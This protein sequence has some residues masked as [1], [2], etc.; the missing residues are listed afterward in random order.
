MRTGHC[1]HHSFIGSPGIEL[2]Q[3]QVT[4]THTEDPASPQY[5]CWLAFRIALKPI[6]PNTNCGRK[7]S[8]RKVCTNSYNWPIIKNIDY[9]NRK[10][11]N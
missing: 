7:K 1:A 4:H 6:L 8:L 3:E 2:T 5:M 10:N 9:K 11:L